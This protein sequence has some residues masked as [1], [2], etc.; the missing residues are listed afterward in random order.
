VPTV[1]TL[2]LNALPAVAVSDAALVMA[3]PLFT[4][5]RKLWLAVPDELAAL[6]VSR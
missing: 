5:S 1:V 6:M 3:S 2:K 4:V